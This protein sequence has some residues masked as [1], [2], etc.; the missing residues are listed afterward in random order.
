MCVC[1]PDTWLLA[2]SESPLD[3]KAEIKR[4]RGSETDQR[5]KRARIHRSKKNE[6]NRDR[7]REVV[8]GGEGREKVKKDKLMKKKNKCMGD[9]E[10]R[11][12]K[13]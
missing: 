4:E 7:W 9:R 10:D 2:S 8:R 3:N 13:K 1:W 5:G 12:R 6:G 11:K